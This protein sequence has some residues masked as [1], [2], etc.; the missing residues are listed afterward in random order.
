VYPLPAWL[1]RKVWR[2]SMRP[3]LCVA[4]LLLAVFAYHFIH[5]ML[6]SKGGFGLVHLLAICATWK[7]LRDEPQEEP[8]DLDLIFAEIEDFEATTTLGE[9]GDEVLRILRLHK[10]TILKSLSDGESPKVIAL[11]QIANVTGDMLES[12]NYHLYRGLLN[13]AG[14]NLLEAFNKALLGMVE[15]DGATHAEITEQLKSVLL[16]IR[17]VG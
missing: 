17:N 16:A 11:A 5:A 12:G 10:K 13:P 8:P 15:A 2:N 6:G 7:L 4:W 14:E 3:V 1:L 9:A